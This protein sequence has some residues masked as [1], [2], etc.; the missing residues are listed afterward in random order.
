MAAGPT[1]PWWCGRADGGDGLIVLLVAVG[2][3]VGAPLRYL[4]D[5]AV[6]ARFGPTAPWGT[7][8]V[9]VVGSL[10]LGALLAVPAGPVVTAAVGTGFCGALTTWSTLGYDTLRLARAGARRAAAGVVL[11]N[12]VAGLAA[13]WVGLALVRLVVG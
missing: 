4:I 1:T 12:V 7:L 9:N 3:A 8:A 13:A 11:L 10:L 2:A 5:R 6:R